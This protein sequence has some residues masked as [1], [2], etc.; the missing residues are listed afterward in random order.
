MLN[1]IKLIL[2][3][4]FL[5]S[6]NKL[7]NKKQIVATEKPYEP[8]C[9]IKG[10]AKSFESPEQWGCVFIESHWSDSFK[11]SHK[12]TNFSFLIFTD[13]RLYNSDL[14]KLDSD[15]LSKCF[16]SKP[17]GGYKE[18][19]D[20]KDEEKRQEKERQDKTTAYFTNLGCQPPAQTGPS[21]TVHMQ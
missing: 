13:G 19:I 4:I 21:D 11:Y 1:K 15:Y 12:I 14:N 8:N 9:F 18:M 17:F 16:L 5:K 10:V 6:T 2:S 20:K 3:H 7:D